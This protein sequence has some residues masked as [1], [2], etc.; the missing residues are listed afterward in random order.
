MY[1][2]K[3]I[4]NISFP[5][6]VAFS[7]NCIFCSRKELFF[8]F[9]QNHEAGLAKSHQHLLQYFCLSCRRRAARRW[10]KRSARRC[11][12]ATWDKCF[13]NLYLQICTVKVKNNMLPWRTHSG[14]TLFFSPFLYLCMSSMISMRSMIYLWYPWYLWYLWFR[15]SFLGFLLSERTTG[16]S[17]VIFIFIFVTG[18]FYLYLCNRSFLSLSL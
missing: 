3:L 18:H 17:P 6:T 8:S 11:G 12:V 1:F 2:S 7:K 10:E 14:G 13:Q 9:V 5:Q 4:W 16:V 15:L